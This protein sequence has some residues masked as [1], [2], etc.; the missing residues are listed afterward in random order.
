[1][2]KKPWMWPTWFYAILST[3]IFAALPLRAQTSAQP[4]TSAALAAFYAGLQAPG[5]SVVTDVPDPLYPNAQARPV[6]VSGEYL[7][8]NALKTSGLDL[9]LQGHWDFSNDIHYVSELSVTNIFNW[10]LILPG[11][12]TEQY[13][14]TQGPYNLSSGAGTPRLRGSWANTVI[15]GPATATLTV[16]HTSGYAEIAEDVGVYPGAC[17]STTPAGTDFPANC[18]VGSFTD[19]DLTG[20]YK[21]NDRVTVTGSIQNLFNKL[22]PFDPAN[23]AGVNYNLTYAQAGIVG[24]FYNLG[25]KFKL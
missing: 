6:V 14:G 7:N 16:Y 21:I 10:Q 11:G 19:F 24:R 15:D 20:S 22:P 18:E 23:Y 5:A 25:V 9:D 3:A 17:L 8:A 12:V 13:V 2:V 4:D 1:M